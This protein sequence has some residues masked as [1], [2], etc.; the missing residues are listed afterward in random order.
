MMTS[1]LVKFLKE[2]RNSVSRENIFNHLLNYDLKIASAHRNYDLEIYKADVDRYGYDFILN[3]RDTFR[4]LQV[5]TVI[6]K[7][8]KWRIQKH[9]LR[10]N[11]INYEI[12]GFE[13]SSEGEG[14][15]GGIIV[16]E[17]VLHQDQIQRY[18][19]FYTDVYI[20][21]ALRA[22]FITKR[23]KMHK[24]NDFLLMLGRGSRTDKVSIPKSYF[25]E[26][27]SVEHLLSLMGLHSR[28]NH[29]WRSDLS[30]YFGLKGESTKKKKEA[31]GE[32]IKKSI[33]DLIIAY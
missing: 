25:V 23:I 13:A 12:L 5:K 9:L 20:L 3:D 28:Y 29:S 31:W 17:V 4:A 6:G 30:V 14:Q 11:P 15:E 16:I 26:A 18:R 10:P 32:E 27:L 22:G 24:L 19:Y 8:N 33:S 21:N 1:Q 7:V 2:S